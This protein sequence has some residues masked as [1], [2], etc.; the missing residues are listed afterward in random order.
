VKTEPYSSRRH[1]LLETIGDGVALIPTAPERIRNRDSSYPY[2]FDSYFWYLTGFPEPE[3]ALVLTGGDKPRLILFCREKDAE[4]EVWQ[5]FHHGPDAAREAFGFDEAYAFGEL[6]RML[7]ELI[8]GRPALWHALG[9]DAGFDA[10]VTAA[11]NAARAGSRAGKRAPDEIRDPRAPLDR[12]RLVKDAHELEIMRR[13]AAIT[14]AGHLAAM[15][16]CCPGLAEYQLEA[17]LSYEFRRRGAAGHAFPPIVASGGNACVLHYVTN[18]RPLADGALVLIDA[19]CE[20]E[21]YAAD[22]TRTFP[23]SGRFSGAQREV[24]E[25]VLAAHAAAVAA[26]R[27]GAPFTAYHDAALRVLAQGLVDLG[28]LAGEIDGLIES[29]AYKPFYMHRTGHWLGLDVHDAGDYK[30]GDAWTPLAVGMTLTVEPGL[31][32]RPAPN[33]PERLHGIGV[34]IEDDVIVTADGA[35]VYTSAPR[36]VAGI[37]EAMRRD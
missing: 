12:M 15:R 22:V 33:V 31:Y 26:I 37:E 17:E 32:L 11:L 7:P 5:G 6:E 3:A 36:T 25:I 24:Y 19:G 29:E 4:R 34:R 14:S 1:V 30:T 35:E 28:V 16:A 9:Y 8:A 20:L 2:R 18:D 13:A 10:I 21:G 23:V 27:P